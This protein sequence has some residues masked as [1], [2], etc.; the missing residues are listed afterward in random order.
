MPE[1]YR[2]QGSKGI[3]EMTEFGLSYMP[4]SGKDTAPSYYTGSFPRAMREAYE[5]QW[6][7]ENLP[8]IGQEPMPE[9]VTFK[10]PDFDDVRPHLMDIFRCRA[11]AEACGGRCRIWP[12]RSAGMPHGERLLFSS[13]GGAME[14]ERSED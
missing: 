4:Q 13:E 14:R 5:K 7:A 8:K 10:G 11:I 9:A 12:P 2:F 3:L 6:R 1:T